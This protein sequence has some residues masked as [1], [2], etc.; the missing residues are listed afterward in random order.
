MVISC[1]GEG[2]REP[3]VS[4]TKKEPEAQLGQE[5]WLWNTANSGTIELMLGAPS[6]PS[7][8]HT[9]GTLIKV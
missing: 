8:L 4:G 3:R 1:L 5:H 2:S 7:K 9:P 6:R